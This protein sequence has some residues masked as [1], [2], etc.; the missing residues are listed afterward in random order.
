MVEEKV[1][2]R[3]RQELKAVEDSVMQRI[4]AQMAAVAMAG[5]SRQ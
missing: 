2:E 5:S 1:Q 3:L 4:M